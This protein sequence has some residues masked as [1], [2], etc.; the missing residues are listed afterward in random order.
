MTKILGIIPARGGS[1]GIPGKNIRMLGGK[2]LIHYA[3][4]AAR[5]SGLVDRLILTTDSP[6]IA[7]AGKSLGIEV[8]FIRP[9][10]LAQDD[11]PMF[12]VIDH[13]LQ[14][15]ENEGWQAEIILLLQP[16]APLRKAEHLQAA[17]RILIGTKCDA[18]AS[19][20]EVPQHYAPDFV[21]K[22]EE[23]KLKPFLEG[24]ERVTRRQDTRPAYSRDGTIYAFRRDV[25]ILKRSIYGDD[26]RPLII[27]RDQ[28][29]N[30]DTLEDWEEAEKRI[31]DQI[32][33][34]P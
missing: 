10:H 9:A 29:C 7:D 5:D 24:G 15:V 20:V 28:S 12:P 3:A 27:P 1:K 26:C 11:T 34:K 2:P 33:E 30:L 18:V 21:L 14:F 4:K 19:V 31:T 8:P 6:E 23:G 13:A 16:T 25:F 17:V 32:Q 22:L